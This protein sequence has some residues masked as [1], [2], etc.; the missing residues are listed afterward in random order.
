MPEEGVSLA[1]LQADVTSLVEGFE[2]GKRLGLMIRSEHTDPF[3][4]T[5][6][7][8]SLFEKEGGELFDVRQAILGHMQQGGKPS[9][10]DRIQATRLAASCIE[11]L[12]QEADQASPAVV[13]IGLQGG[14][15]DFTGLEDFPRLVESGYQR[16]KEQWWLGLRALARIMAQPGPQI[17][18]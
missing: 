17:D 8:C 7:M 15:V 5:D 12:T 18:D 6:F 2:Q 4:S 14:R 10:F 9:P 1:D 11:F 16:P 3:Y 13:A